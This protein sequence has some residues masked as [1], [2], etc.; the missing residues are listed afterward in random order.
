MKIY[1]HTP[2]HH[3]QQSICQ[4][5]KWLTSGET[6]N[7]HILNKNNVSFRALQI[8]DH[9]NEP[10]S[11]FWISSNSIHLFGKKFLCNYAPR[12]HKLIEYGLCRTT[13]GHCC[14]D[15]RLESIYQTTSL[16]NRCLSVANRVLYTW[17]CA[18]SRLI[19][20]IQSSSLGPLDAKMRP[21][22]NCHFT[23]VATL[24][25]TQFSSQYTIKTV[26]LANNQFRKCSS[27]IR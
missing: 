17:V 15:N 6:R 25:E 3:V 24:D 23:V 18:R 2:N 19:F 1:I 14:A 20:T 27:F 5:A 9:N 8:P 26:C 12:A 7:E 4:C 22:A 16:G 10:P 21:C 11:I 13:R